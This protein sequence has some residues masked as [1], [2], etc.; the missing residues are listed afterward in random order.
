MRS[1]SKGVGGRKK[2]RAASV[3]VSRKKQLHVFITVGTTKFDELIK[4]VFEDSSFCSS[5]TQLQFQSVTVQCGN[6][7]VPG[8]DSDRSASTSFDSHG[9]R[10]H[11][12]RFKP[13]IDD[14][15]QQADLVISHAGAGSIFESLRAKKPLIVVI[16]NTLADNHQ[17]ELA[18]AMCA[19]EHCLSC[20]PST[21][22]STIL[23]SSSFNFAPLSPSNIALDRSIRSINSL[24]GFV[25]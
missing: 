23:E 2:S 6:S 12:Y 19:R 22:S 14:D 10:F 1:R 15:L 21:L 7:I 18:D 16:N 25:E 8:L 20:V 11:C 9:I 17:V 13:S 24:M 4:A 5:L 3:L